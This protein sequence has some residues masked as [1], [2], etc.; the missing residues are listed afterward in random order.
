MPTETNPVDRGKAIPSEPVSSL[1]MK[2]NTVTAARNVAKL[3]SN[4]TMGKERSSA[5]GS[6]DFVLNLAFVKYLSCETYK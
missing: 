4:K 6:N 1:P 5:R 3:Q 2:A